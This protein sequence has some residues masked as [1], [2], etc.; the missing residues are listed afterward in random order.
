M[1]REEVEA[2]ARAGKIRYRID[3]SNLVPKYLRNDIR[4]NLIPYLKT[5]FNPNIAASL[6]RLS[7]ILRADSDFIDME[8]QAALDRALIEKS[9]L[10]KGLVT[11]D[12]R[13]LASL[14]NA[15]K[16][17]VLMKAIWLL[18]GESDI[19]STHIISAIKL[20]GG[21]RP[22]ASINLPGGYEVRRAY[23]R[24]VIGLAQ[25]QADTG[26]G[27][28]FNEPLKLP[29][30][31]VLGGGAGSFKASYSSVR[32][33]S[34]DPGANTAFFDADS[35]EAGGPYIFRPISPGD[36]MVPFG[37]SGS[38]KVKEILMEKKLSP[39]KRRSVPMLCSA[40]EVIWAVGV[41]QS[42]RHSVGQDTRKVVRIEFKKP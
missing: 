22:N 37:M 18:T 33:S 3:S 20:I 7:A 4:L 31:T 5:N 19:Y 8:A 15:L 11:L 23:D 6:V 39:K 24:V 1:S 41:R 34:F 21:R 16:A 10:R 28:R 42:R 36:R 26:E 27:L 40:D 17:R 2:Y 35:F 13:V 14:H 9:S 30:T 29:G 38:K 32:P 12:R 25:P